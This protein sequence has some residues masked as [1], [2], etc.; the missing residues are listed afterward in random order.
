MKLNPPLRL[1]ASAV[2]RAL[3]AATLMLGTHVAL[4]DSVIVLNSAGD[5]LSLLTQKPIKLKN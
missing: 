3:V 1:L 4:A 2:S 5:S